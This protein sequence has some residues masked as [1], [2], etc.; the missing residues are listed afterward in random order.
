MRR[1]KLDDDTFLEVLNFLK[2]LSENN[3]RLNPRKFKI[4]LPS[5]KIL[6]VGVE[7]NQITENG[8]GSQI[9]E[10]FEEV[11]RLFPEIEPEKASENF[12]WSLG[13][14]DVEG[15]KMIRFETN[16]AKKHLSR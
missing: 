2:T 12:T 1:K 5:D 10:S 11:I 9:F 4:P 14:Q 6:L 7:N 3:N 8:M 13:Y 16:Q 15:E